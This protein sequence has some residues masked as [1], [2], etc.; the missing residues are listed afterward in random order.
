MRVN[1]DDETDVQTG[2]KFGRQK[3][4]SNQSKATAA[5]AAR[6]AGDSAEPLWLQ[7]DDELVEP[8]PPRQVVSETAYVLF[9][10]RR[11]LAPSN[12]ARYSTLD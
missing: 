3:V 6:A 7:F 11:R 1:T 4:D 12:I 8:I 9:Y 5:A 2:W 10:R